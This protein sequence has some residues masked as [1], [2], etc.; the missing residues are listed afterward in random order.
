MRYRFV[1]I[2]EIDK[3]GNKVQVVLQNRNKY[4][5]LQVVV[6]IEG[7]SILHNCSPCPFNLDC[8]NTCYY[9]GAAIKD[10]ISKMRNSIFIANP[11][12]LKKIRRY[13][14]E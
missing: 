3:C 9:I 6:V 1:R 5:L 10:R 13:Y 14:W 4:P 8:H 7:D 2:G 11:I 12:S